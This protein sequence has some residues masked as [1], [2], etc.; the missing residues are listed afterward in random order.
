MP[1]VLRGRKPSHPQGPSGTQVFRLWEHSGWSQYTLTEADGRK[2]TVGICVKCRNYRGQWRRRG[3][4]VLVYAYWGLVPPSCAWV[5]QTYRQRFAIEAS[6]RQMHQA[7]IRT[8]SRSPVVRLFL[9]G[10]ALLLRN[11]WVWLHW[12]VL[13]TPSGTAAAQPGSAAVPDAVGVAAA[14]GRGTLRSL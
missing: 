11:V 13:S 6:Y 3:C 8:C 2:A 4:Q 7:R 5:R 1:V 12:E 10:V 9:I 14:R